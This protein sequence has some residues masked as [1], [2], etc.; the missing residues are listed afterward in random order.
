MS[1]SEVKK[2][3]NIAG[4]YIVGFVL[5]A[6]LMILAY[7]I[8]DKHTMSPSGMYTSLTIITVVLLFVQAAFFLRLNTSSTDSMWDL[9][10]FLFTILILAIVVIGTLWIMYNMVH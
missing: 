8:V 6:I 1:G 2:S 5:S 10:T 3:K 9:M 7:Y 4:S